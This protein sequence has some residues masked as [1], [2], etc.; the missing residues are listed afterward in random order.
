MYDVCN[1]VL[2]PHI[3]T[4]NLQTTPCYYL[5]INFPHIHSLAFESVAILVY[6]ANF[7]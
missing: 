3:L 4:F 1:D 5:I 7:V 2:F 6:H